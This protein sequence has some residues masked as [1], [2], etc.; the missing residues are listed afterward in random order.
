QLQLE[1]VLM[2]SGELHRAVCEAV[3]SALSDGLRVRS[4][5]QPL[6]GPDHMIV[7]LVGFLTCRPDPGARRF[8][9]HYA[10]L[11]YLLHRASGHEARSVVVDHRHRRIRRAE[12][13]AD[14][15][16]HE[17]LLPLITTFARRIRSPRMT[18]PCSIVRMTHRVG[19]A[20]VATS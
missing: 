13:D 14:A 17:G 2:A 20:S 8:E 12:V 4:S 7:G 15:C 3:L 5:H 1:I 11:E 18:K 19:D 16:A 10:R 9:P 6:D